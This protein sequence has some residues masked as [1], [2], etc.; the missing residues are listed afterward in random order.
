MDQWLAYLGLILGYL[1]T[2][3]LIRWALLIKKRHPTSTIAWILA[4]IFL[5]FLGGLLFLIFGINRVERRLAMKEAA[6]RD[7]AKSLPRLNQYEQGTD[8]T[9][10]ADQQALMRIAALACGSQPTD[11]NRVIL[12]NHADIAYQE[13]ERAIES[14]KH[15]IHLEY[16]IWKADRTGHRMRDL[17]IEQARAGVT[18]R[19]LYDGIGSI[20]LTHK[21]LKPM[22]EAGIQVVHFLPGASFRERWSINLRSHRKIVVVDGQTGFTGGMNIGD[23]YRGWN[24]KLGYWRDTHLKLNGPTVLQLQLVFAEDWYYATGEELTDPLWYPQPEQKGDLFAQVVSGGPIGEVRTFHALMFS[25]INEARERV[26][27]ATS[28]FVPTDALVMALETA[29]VRGVDVR[30]LVPS[31]AEYPFAI[32]AGRSDYDSLLRA[33]V[34]IY[35]Y[36]RGIL[37]SKTLTVDGHWSLVGTPNFDPRSLLL[38]FEVAVAIYGKSIAKELEAHFEQDI[39]YARKIELAEWEKRPLRQVFLENVCRLA[40]PIL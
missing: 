20:G 16:Y 12:L 23:E 9:F 8:N 38:N 37:H 27:L 26:T 4:I 24:K 19:F 7:I 3:F 31:K 34:K 21:F 13:I 32:L 15:S 18:V 6:S 5:P 39:Q 17:L 35:E 25:A 36:Q 30:L 33:G 2:L 10:T 1:L 14:A 40:S 22:R 11:K 29:A 28:F